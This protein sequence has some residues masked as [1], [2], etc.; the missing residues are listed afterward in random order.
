MCC[1]RIETERSPFLQGHR[2][3]SLRSGYLSTNLWPHVLVG[4]AGKGQNGERS[5]LAPQASSQSTGFNSQDS[6]LWRRG[7]K[8]AASHSYVLD[9]A[10]FRRSMVPEL[11]IAHF[12]MEGM[13][14]WC[15]Q[16]NQSLTLV[17]LQVHQVTNYLKMCLI[18]RIF[19]LNHRY[20]ALIV[21]LH[22]IA[23]ESMMI[24]IIY[25]V[26]IFE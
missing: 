8:K 6:Q 16:F 11:R 5:F 7:E 4:E 17:V 9:V 1:G 23:F 10:D 21:W 22:F 3:H 24:S 15:C 12:K 2:T 26:G 18:F 19:F 25:A 20:F 13:I 14:V